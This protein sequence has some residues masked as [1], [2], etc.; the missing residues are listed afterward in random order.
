MN[1]ERTIDT[2]AVVTPNCAI[3]RRSHTN[4]YKTLQ[5]P[6]IKKKKKYQFTRGLFATQG[7]ATG[8]WGWTC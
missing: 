5:N 2:M 3:D 4:S 8:D 6:E 1:T 7:V